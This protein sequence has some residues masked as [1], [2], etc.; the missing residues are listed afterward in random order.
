[1]K[2]MPTAFLLCLL[3]YLFLF[4]WFPMESGWL[5]ALL[6]SI[7]LWRGWTTGTRDKTAH[8]GK[9]K[10]GHIAFASLVYALGL[11]IDS[12]LV[13]SL[14]WLGWIRWSGKGSCWPFASLGL[15]LYALP[16]V[17]YDFAIVNVH[18]RLAYAWCLEQSASLLALP[19]VRDGVFVWI[20]STPI[21][22][23]PP[24]AGLG[25]WQLLS[26]AGGLLLVK[27][28]PPRWLWCLPLGLCGLAF[29]I[30]LVR[31]AIS[32]Y[33][34]HALRWQTM[35]PH[36]HEGIGLALLVLTMAAILHLRTHLEK[37]LR[38]LPVLP[39]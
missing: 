26:L 27:T 14:G 18:V 12:I 31:I 5:M 35:N 37:R 2:A 6:G 23:D 17:V 22:I 29:L 13:T 7:A 32:S 4:A 38:L 25:T 34:S 30:G 20:D 16:W 24:C 11:G 3:P 28:I 9:D 8:S 15:A 1:M 19:V 10:L 33:L 36:L 39:G 21:A